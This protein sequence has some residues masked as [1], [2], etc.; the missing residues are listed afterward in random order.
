MITVDEAPSSGE[1]ADSSSCCGQPLFPNVPSRSPAGAP[2]GGGAVGALLLSPFVKAGTT[3]EEPFNHFSLLRTIED[4]F[5]LKHLGY[6]GLSAVKSFEPSMFTAAQGLSTAARAA[7]ASPHAGELLVGDRRAAR[8]RARQ[9]PL[10]GHHVAR[11]LEVGRV[12]V[13]AQGAGRQQRADAHERR[14]EDAAQRPGGGEAP[15]GGQPARPTGSDPV[16]PGDADR[17]RA[18]ASTPRLRAVHPQQPRPP[19]EPEAQRLAQRG[20]VGVGGGDEAVRLDAGE[21]EHAPAG[22][23]RATG[24]LAVQ[25][26]ELARPLTVGP[27]EQLPRRAARARAHVLEAVLGDRVAGAAALAQPLAPSPASARRPGAGRARGSP[28]G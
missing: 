8:A 13:Q 1:F 22:V 7:Q 10:Q 14:R 18:P 5:G 16:C 12:Q 19:A 15:G 20:G 26:D 28:A 3:N 4:L 24:L 9:H 23:D 11:V 25:P 6:A 17:S 2:R 27:G 21:L